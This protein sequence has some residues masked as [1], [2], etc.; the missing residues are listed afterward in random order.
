MNDVATALLQ[1][2]PSIEERAIGGVHS[3]VKILVWFGSSKPGIIH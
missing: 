3:F 2:S 1:N